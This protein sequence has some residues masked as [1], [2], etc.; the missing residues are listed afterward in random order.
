M[1]AACLV[2]LGKWAS[3]T[4]SV[5]RRVGRCDLRTKWKF[6]TGST[7]PFRDKHPWPRE[8]E[9]EP[10]PLFD[11]FADT[12]AAAKSSKC[13]NR[14]IEDTWDDYDNIFY[15]E[16]LK[17]SIEPTRFID[18]D[19]IRLLGIRSDLEDMFVELGMGNMA[20]NPKV[21]YPELVR[22]FMAMVN[23]YY[24]NERAKR[25]SEGILTFFI[26]GIHYRV[27]LSA[28]STIY[29]FQNTELQHA[30]G[31]SAAAF[32]PFPP[33]PDMSTR[34][35]GDFQR[36]VVDALIAIWARVSRCLSLFEQ[37]ECASQLTISSRTITPA[38]GRLRGVHRRDY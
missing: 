2:Q 14:A 33:M 10:I 23:V 7:A 16:W 18:P 20:T 35:E 22:Q 36:V 11:H 25:A 27:P 8:R 24:A 3:W 9:E 34:P 32:S 37:E 4:S 30:V 1:K 28:L 5:G 29:G 12:H 21:L 13:R 15:N 26:R 31:Q 17:V 19:V 6:D 38:Q